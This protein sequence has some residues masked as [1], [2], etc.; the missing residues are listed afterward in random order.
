MCANVIRRIV[1]AGRTSIICL[2]FVN[3]SCMRSEARSPQ[4]A[5]RPASASRPAPVSRRVTEPPSSGQFGL[6]VLVGRS[7]VGPLSPM[8]FAGSGVQDRVSRSGPFTGLLVGV[9]A[10]A[11]RPGPW[12]H[13]YPQLS[14]PEMARWISIPWT[15]GITL[16]RPFQMV[17]HPGRPYE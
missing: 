10:P 13:P 7:R 6:E 5:S 9:S 17:R 3:V 4:V 12:P 2:A 8:H 14:P 16:A 11:F 1:G 15:I